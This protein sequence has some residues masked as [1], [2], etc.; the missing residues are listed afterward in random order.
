V[1]TKIIFVFRTLPRIRHDSEDEERTHLFNSFSA[2]WKN[3]FAFSFFF[4]SFEA[5]CDAPISTRDTGP[6]IEARKQLQRRTLHLLSNGSHDPFIP[7]RNHINKDS[8][9]SC[10]TKRTRHRCWSLT[11]GTVGC[12]PSCLRVGLHRRS[13][14]DLG[15]LLSFGILS[16]LDWPSVGLV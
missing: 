11:A 7:Y 15:L 14:T 3:F 13:V 4:F 2:S 16:G 8:S 10:E 9:G 12:R 5:V 6:E 1:L